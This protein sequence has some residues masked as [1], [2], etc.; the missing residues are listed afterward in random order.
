[1]SSARIAAV[2]RSTA[3]AMAG[4]TRRDG[5]TSWRA[6][7]ASPGP[8]QPITDRAKATVPAKSGR[9]TQAQVEQLSDQYGPP[10]REPWSEQ[11]TQTYE[12]E[13]PA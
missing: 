3:S 12:T 7:S 1:M 8:V 11:R 4:S 2:F 10:A 13:W 9:R 5:A 6:A